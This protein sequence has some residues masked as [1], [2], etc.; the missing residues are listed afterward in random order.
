MS[1]RSFSNDNG[2]RYARSSPDGQAGAKNK[3]RQRFRRLQ[4]QLH[5]EYFVP[6]FGVSRRVYPTEETQ[7][8][9]QK[10]KADL[11][12]NYNVLNVRSLH[13]S[14]LNQR[15]IIGRVRE[16]EFLPD[17]GQIIESAETT[18]ENLKKSLEGVPRRLDVPVGRVDSFG[19]P[20]RQTKVGIS[21]KGWKGFTARY[22]ERAADA[23][24]TILPM[25]VIIRETNIVLGN[26]ITALGGNEGV[27]GIHTAGLATTPHITVAQKQK[28]GSISQ[29]E[30]QGM[31]AIV[32]QAME[33]VGLEAFSL[34]DPVVRAKT[35]SN[36]EPVKF[37]ARSP[38]AYRDY[39]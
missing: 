9:L 25:P 28:G 39:L 11:P 12:K 37:L 31:S 38:R 6:M 36:E 4:Q 21:P 26:V 10:L 30:I 17:E 13:M 3:N 15:K 16:E 33:D 14:I 22:A 5:P 7:D 29:S 34:L 1:R 32:E 23:Q 27:N 24:K 35:A 18:A 2:I 8:F 20:G 19:D